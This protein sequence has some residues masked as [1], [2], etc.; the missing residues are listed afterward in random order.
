MSY[1]V[2]YSVNAYL[3]EGGGT[4]VEKCKDKKQ[5]KAFL[6]YMNKVNELCKTNYSN[7]F[8]K[9]HII[10]NAPSKV[11]HIAKILDLGDITE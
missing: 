11:L 10:E 1:I 2:V 3:E 8:I 5:V 9:C 7:D 6:K 4:N